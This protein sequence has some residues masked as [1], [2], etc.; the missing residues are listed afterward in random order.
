MKKLIRTILTIRDEGVT[1]QKIEMG[2][3][4]SSSR[5]MF[6]VFIK[7]FS[8]NLSDFFIYRKSTNRKLTNWK[9]K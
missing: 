7:K 8:I 5:G 4:G 6:E 3:V 1:G 2:W 9:I